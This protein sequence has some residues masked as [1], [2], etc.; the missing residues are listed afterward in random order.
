MLS[1]NTYK[2]EGILMFKLLFALTAIATMACPMSKS[3]ETPK[4]EF[5]IS[6]VKRANES[7]EVAPE[8]TQS[9]S[10]VE[11]TPVW[12]N[13]VYSYE[14]EGGKYEI[15]LTSKTE[16]TLLATKG[17]MSIS[18]KGTY[19]L[20]NN[21]LTLSADGEVL[22]KF[23]IVEGKLSKHVEGSEPSLDDYTK[24][25]LI[26][27][28]EQLSQELSKE[29][30]NWNNIGKI[31]IG[32]VTVAGTAIVSL[33]IA[34][35]RSKIK[36]VNLQKLVDKAL[37]DAQDTC[38][39]CVDEVKSMVVDVNVTVQKAVNNAEYQRKAEAEAN[40]IKLQ[41]SVQEAKANLEINDVLK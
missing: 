39:K 6:Y 23:D 16:Y 12:E 13:I 24:E 2:M 26:E 41:Q 29:Q 32:I 15:T 4:P 1:A 36:Q 27:L 28:V 14:D 31:L 40:S 34:V 5:Q 30:I 3:Q 25:S 8:S 35:L 21:L 38:N 33:L 9:S 7:T 11:E 18:I 20:E 10:I 37:A 19:T 17:S 22:Y